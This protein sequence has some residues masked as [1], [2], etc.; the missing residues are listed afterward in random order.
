MSATKPAIEIT[1]KGLLAIHLWEQFPDESSDEIEARA[2]RLIRS[3]R[4][5]NEREE[6]AWRASLADVAARRSERGIA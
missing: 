3:S 2:M 4:P 5:A 6:S 1:F